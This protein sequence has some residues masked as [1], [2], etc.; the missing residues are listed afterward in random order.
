MSRITIAI[1]SSTTEC[2]REQREREGEEGERP[3]RAD[4]R[5]RPAAVEQT[6][7]ALGGDRPG[8]PGEPEEPDGRRRVGEGRRAEQERQ[9]RPEHREGP[10]SRRAHGAASSAASAPPEHRADR[11]D[12]RR[13][14]DARLRRQAAGSCGRACREQDVDGGR[15]GEHRAPAERA[16]DQAAHRPRDEDAREDPG[17]DGADDAP[18]AALSARSPAS[19]ARI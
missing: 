16:G 11:G 14:G 19:G 15:G 3:R 4:D 6:A 18:A 17:D 12:Q 1:T 7:R 13:V 8:E 9:R 2:A 5:Q 10:E